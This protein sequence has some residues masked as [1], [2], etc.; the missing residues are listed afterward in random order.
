MK[1]PKPLLMTKLMSIGLRVAP[2]RTPAEAG[3]AYEDVEFT[4]SDHLDIK[5]WFVPAP[6]S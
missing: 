4:A 5:G 1:V 2:D 3:L 6:A